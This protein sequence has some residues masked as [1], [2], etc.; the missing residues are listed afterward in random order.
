MTTVVLL[1]AFGGSSRS[2]DLVTPR[3]APPCV[4]PD[5]RGFGGSDA[6]PGPYDVASYA[7]DVLALVAD[8]EEYVL[9]GHSMGGKFALAAAAHRPK[10]LRGL[11]L[12]AP[13]P[14]TPE[15][16]TDESRQRTLDAWG[17]RAAVEGIVA[18]VL[19]LPIPPGFR[20]ATING[21]L[22]ASERAWRAWLE[23]GSLENVSDRM[24]KID[25]PVYIVVGTEDPV[26]GPKTQRDEVASRLASA[27]V[28]EVPGA[29][30]LLPIEAP[31]AVAAA[32]LSATNG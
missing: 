14:P 23:I 2:W 30:H 21:Y 1:H 16:M 3:L 11:V 27:S 17:D 19:R 32:I 29:G 31:D 7:A 20:E 13:S 8:L 15:P 18:S 25:V 6:P 9:V 26:V 5:L 4:A 22:A 10:G 28:E 24:A 12:V